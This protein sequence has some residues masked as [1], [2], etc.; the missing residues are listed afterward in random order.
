M[1]GAV[2]AFTWTYDNEGRVEYLTSHTDT[3][4]DT[5][6]WTDAANQI[7]YTYNAA[8]RLTK[9]EQEEDGK[10]DGSTLSVQ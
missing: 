6:T 7:K 10:V 3:T 1:D 2:R 8:D 4:P 5:S 9:E